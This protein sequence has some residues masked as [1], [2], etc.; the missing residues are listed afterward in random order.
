ML[1]EQTLERLTILKLFGMA[2]SLKTRLSRPDHSELSHSDLVGLIV[3]DEWNKREKRR[4]E[5]LLRQAAFKDQAS[6]EDLNY[7]SGRNLKKAQVQELCRF[8]WLSARQN[9]L[10]TGPTGAGKSYLSQAVGNRA[11]RDGHSV[12]Y[13]RIS[14]LIAALRV[15][16]AEGTYL[17]YLKRLVRAKMLILDDLGGAPRGADLPRGSRDPPA[18]VAAVA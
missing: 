5:N 9:Y 2:E 10:I 17:N 1:I 13:F 11:C 18:I 4:N 6:V 7:R 14:K 12:L 15:A 16:R 3:D 8:G